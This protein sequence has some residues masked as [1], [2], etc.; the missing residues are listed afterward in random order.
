MLN[1]IDISN[2]QKNIIPSNLKINFCICKATEGTYFVDRFCD[3]F[4]TN[5][6]E[7]GILYGFYHFAGT[8]NP[9]DEAKFFFDNC[10]GYVGEGI[11]VLDYEVWGENTND[12]EWCERFL[13]EFRHLS[14]VW[15]VLY[16]SASHCKDFHAS[17]WIP[18][19]CGLWVAGYPR[20]F[21][22]WP[23]LDDMPYDISPWKL[24][25]LW[26][27]ASDW[28]LA[29]YNGDL[30]GDVAFMN[31]TAWGKY[32]GAKVGKHEGT[33]EK[34]AKKKVSISLDGKKYSGYVSEK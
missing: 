24:A 1:G 14:G 13:T 29:G 22:Q 6:K 30:D 8:G 20:D 11:P 12:V 3:A 33:A 9:A 16:I 2:W 21:H 17:A 26:Q 34:P 18:Q 10:K 7:S 32:A 25:A 31:K 4:I 19:T 27:F 23:T 15:P 5:C 28:K